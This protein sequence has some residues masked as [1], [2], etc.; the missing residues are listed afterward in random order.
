MGQGRVEMGGRWEGLRCWAGVGEK[1]EN[2]TWTTIKKLQKKILSSFI[3]GNVIIICLDVFL[4]GSNFFGT[5]WASWTPWKSISFARLGKFSFIICS[6]KFSISSSSSSPSGTHMIQML[7]H[8]KMSWRFLS[9]SSFFWILVF[10]F[11]SGW[12]FISSFSSKLLIWVLVSFL[13]LVPCRF[14]F[15][16]HNATFIAAWVFFM[17][18]KYPVSSWSILITSVLKCVSDRL[19]ISL[20]SSCIFFWSFELFFHLDFFFFF[21]SW[22]TC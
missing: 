18:L 9:L 1:A 17:L 3:L 14:F 21:W 11:C 7:E 19:A 13:S 15:I 4:L 5:P 6:N 20:L 2:C 12:M 10:S 8:L 16:S 22:C